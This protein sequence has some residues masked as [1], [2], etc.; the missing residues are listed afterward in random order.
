[1]NTQH[2]TTKH[3]DIRHHFIRELVEEGKVE[4]EYVKIENQLADLF[5]KAL[6]AL[7]K[8]TK[9]HIHVAN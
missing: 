1:M 6:D 2:S 3:I 7:R 5:T 8:A 9:M 4:L